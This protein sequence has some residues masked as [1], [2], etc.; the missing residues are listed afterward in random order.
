MTMVINQV[1]FDGNQVYDSNRG[2][3]FIPHPTTHN[4]LSDFSDPLNLLFRSGNINISI[5]PQKC[6]ATLAGRGNGG[7]GGR[8]FEG[9]Q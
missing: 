4:R 8:S 2:I 5:L 7:G 9:F 3:L 6:H 1:K